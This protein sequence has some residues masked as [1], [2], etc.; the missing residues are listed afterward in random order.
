MRPAARQQAVIDLLIALAQG[1]TPADRVFERWARSNRYAGS[2]DRRVIGEVFFSI[3]RNRRRLLSAAGLDA[4]A[5]DLDVPR[6]ARLLVAFYWRLFGDATLDDIAALFDGSRFAPATLTDDE[7]QRLDAFVDA[8]Q[9]V[10]VRASVPEWAEAGMAAY[11]ASDYEA[12]AEFLCQRAAIDIRVNSQL[13][14]RN[15]V[16]ELLREDDIETEPLAACATAL[17]VVEGRAVSQSDVFQK[18]LIEIQDLGSQIV[19][20]A[21]ASY[22]EGRVLDYCAG[23]GGKALALADMAPDT[24]EI[25]VHDANPSRMRDLW[26]RA[27]RA[28]ITHIQK[29]KLAHAEKSFNMVLADVP[30]SGSGRWRRNPE[31]KWLF[32]ADDLQKIMIVQAQILAEAAQFVRPNG[33]LAYITCSVLEQENT[34]QISSFCAKNSEFQGPPV[35]Q[36]KVTPATFQS[37]GLYACVLQRRVT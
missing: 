21:L 33:Y 32:S 23:A 10:A 9:S 6:V 34:A 1:G 7:R 15:E 24:R 17:R 11:L 30:C 26:R 37:D 31:Q 14:S 22:A 8:P 5:A 27:E 20:A 13:I 36:I 28:G 29:A 19:S 2:K 4:A 12:S 16:Q 3:L 35:T 25:A 18:G